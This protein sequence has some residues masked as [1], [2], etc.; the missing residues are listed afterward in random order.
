MTSEMT[1]TP[2]R[3]RRRALPQMVAA[4]LLLSACA[5]PALSADAPMPRRAPQVAVVAGPGA[6][7]GA[8]ARAVAAGR[9]HAGTPAAAV[10]VRRVGGR[11]EADAQAV[12]L[13]GAGY[14]VV[15]G[16]GP[17][18]RAAVG[19]AAAAAVGPGVTWLPAR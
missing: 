8:I 10:A 11:M 16:V 4:A 19:Q 14:G 13:A 12:A 9:R 15:V 3:F 6:D 18:G 1:T 2:R 5:V 17:E 7:A